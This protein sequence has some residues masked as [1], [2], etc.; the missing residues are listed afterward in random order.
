MEWLYLLHFGTRRLDGMVILEVLMVDAVR[1][2]QVGVSRD[3]SFKLSLV[4]AW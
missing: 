2:M 1:S 4:T 3:A